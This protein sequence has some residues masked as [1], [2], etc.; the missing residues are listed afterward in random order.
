MMVLTGGIRVDFG[1]PS[2]PSN[3][4]EHASRQ[5]CILKDFYNLEKVSFIT[6]TNTGSPIEFKEIWSVWAPIVPL[7]EYVNKTRKN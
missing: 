2:I 3:Y 1:S 5:S 7:I 6:Q 4:R